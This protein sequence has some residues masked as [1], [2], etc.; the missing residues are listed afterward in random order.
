MTLPALMLLGISPLSALATN[1]LQG[2]MGTATATFVLLK[3]KSYL[4]RHKKIF[5]LCF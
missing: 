1:K 3:R 2:T 4:E 5:A